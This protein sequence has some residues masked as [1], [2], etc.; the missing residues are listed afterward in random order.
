[1]T[2]KHQRTKVDQFQAQSRAHK[3]WTIRFGTPE[4][5]VFPEEIESD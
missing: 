2:K 4:Y 5:L 3:N 1:M